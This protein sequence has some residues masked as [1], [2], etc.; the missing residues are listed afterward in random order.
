MEVELVY[1]LVL[2]PGMVEMFRAA[3]PDSVS[4]AAINRA[5]FFR[6]GVTTWAVQIYD[7]KMVAVAV[8]KSQHHQ[9]IPQSQVIPDTPAQLFPLLHQPEAQQL[10]GGDSGWLA[11]EI[12]EQQTGEVAV[13]TFSPCNIPPAQSD[14]SLFRG[15]VVSCLH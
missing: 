10:H 15:Q 12:L 4:A 7:V 5:V 11:G 13:N 2:S 1:K 8:R 9:Q 3:A 6:A 14:Q